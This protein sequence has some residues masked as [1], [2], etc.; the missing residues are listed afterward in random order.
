M[1]AT[2]AYQDW[3]MNARVTMVKSNIT[4]KQLADLLGLSR[5]HVTKVTSG[6][7]EKAWPAICRIS[8]ALGIDKP[9][10]EGGM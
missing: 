4:N 10:Y 9:D 2:K 7:Q 8:K 6:G 3:S 5:Q 1:G